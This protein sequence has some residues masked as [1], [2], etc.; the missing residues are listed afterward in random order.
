MKVNKKLFKAIRIWRD[1]QFYFWLCFYYIF[2]LPEIIYLYVY[3]EVLY[4]KLVLISFCEYIK[5]NLFP[6]E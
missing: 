2:H 4:F 5:E 3:I 1:F 6:D